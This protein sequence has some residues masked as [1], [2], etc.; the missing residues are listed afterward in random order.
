MITDP[1]GSVIVGRHV[2]QDG[3]FCS[4]G[5]FSGA[6]QVDLSGS[7]AGPKE[8]AGQF[9]RLGRLVTDGAG[10]FTAKTIANYA[11][12]QVQE[13]FTGTYDV[14]AKCFVTLKY[15]F[16]GEQL[17]IYGA[18]GGHGETAMMMVTS[19]GWAVSGQ[20]RAQQ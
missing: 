19:P 5:D 18:L 8:R 15:S 16:G 2:K 3:R 20:L 6:Y 10:N 14:N 13:D 17:T 4:I 9:Q 1:P 7:V 12:R 11:G